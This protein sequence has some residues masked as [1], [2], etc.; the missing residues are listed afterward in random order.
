MLLILLA[1]STTYYEVTLRNIENRYNKH[2]ETFGNLTADAVTEQFNKTTNLKEN[3]VKYKEYLER[4]YDELNTLNKNLK[5]EV[6]SLKAES[7]VAKS[8]IEYQKAQELGP[9]EQFKLFQN[10]NDEIAKLKEKIKE[11]C[12][13]LETYNVSDSN[14]FGIN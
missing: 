4:R 10:K 3:I 5:N 8:Q 13:K 1:S 6:E 2:Q 7:A 14:C 12:S 11:L 9:T